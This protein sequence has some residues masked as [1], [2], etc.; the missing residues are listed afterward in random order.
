MGILLKKYKR[1][2]I[3]VKSNNKVMQKKPQKQPLTCCCF[4]TI[5]VFPAESTEHQQ[6]LEGQS[7][8]LVPGKVK[9]LSV[10]SK[11]TEGADIWTEEYSPF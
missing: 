9:E 1:I 10:I 6:T 4:Y 8:L 11:V 5:P 3:N 7:H 2:H